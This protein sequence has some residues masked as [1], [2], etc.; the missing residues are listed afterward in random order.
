[1]KT[2]D[3][4]IE[5]MAREVQM[6]QLA[7]YYSGDEFSRKSMRQISYHSAKAGFKACE[8]KMLAEAASGFEGFYKSSVQDEFDYSSMR[9]DEKALRL[10]DMRK[11]FTAGAMS[12]AKRVKELEDALSFYANYDNWNH[13]H[14]EP[15]FLGVDIGGKAYAV[16]QEALK[17]QK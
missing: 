11:A 4:D 17:Q 14:E 12:Q 2:N 1:M 6:A 8:A 5:K 7:C 10:M 3:K 16:A 13:A 9:H 15:V